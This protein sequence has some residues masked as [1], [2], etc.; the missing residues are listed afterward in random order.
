[1]F[2]L[3]VVFILFLTQAIGVNFVAAQTQSEK[4]LSPWVQNAQ[5]VG[6]G[7]LTFLGIKAYD[8]TLY[9]PNG[10]WRKEAPFA[11]QLDY[12]RAFSGDSIAKTSAQEIDRLGAPTSAQ[13]QSWLAEMT[14]ILPDVKAGDHII[15]IH[16]PTSGAILLQNGRIL[17]EIKDPSF[18]RLFFDIWLS[19]KTRVAGLRKDLLGQ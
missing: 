4:I 3:F 14:D 9:A 17:G 5:V 2:R 1:M 7:R 8:A 13:L 12:L 19:P 16:H 11:L 15:G 6:S 18:S 10:V